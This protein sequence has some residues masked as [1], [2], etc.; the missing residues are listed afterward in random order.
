[1]KKD[2]IF[3]MFERSIIPK[4]EIE[5]RPKP[6]YIGC[7]VSPGE[8]G[9]TALDLSVNLS[10]RWNAKIKFFSWVRYYIDLEKT[11]NRAIAEEELLEQQIND[12]YD[13]K[14]EINPV[15]S[16]RPIDVKS[17]LHEM[18]EKEQRSVDLMLKYASEGSF[19]LFSIPIPI[20]G[21]ESHK[22]DT[23]GEEAEVLLRRTPRS[24]PICLVPQ[25]TSGDENTVVV[26]V[27]PD[28]ITQLSSRIL[29]FF[30]QNTKVILISVLDPKLVDIFHLMRTSE[31]DETEPPTREE[32]EQLMKERL[33]G[34][35]EQMLATIRGKVK[36][37]QIEITSGTLGLTLSNIV[38]THN[39]ANILVFSRASEEDLLDHDVDIIGR[40]VPKTRIFIVWN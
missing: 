6:K 27:H 15:M 33:R 40:L 13:L 10:K 35:M 28:V 37:V 3:L 36:S 30:D 38:E 24:L 39:A 18:V 20:F 14:F 34:F 23:L 29:Q 2:E 21:D 1:M 16:P 11:L 9:K 8:F 31:K 5:E 12:K 25:E 17:K 19:D 7:V 26:V 4:I 32:I 22:V